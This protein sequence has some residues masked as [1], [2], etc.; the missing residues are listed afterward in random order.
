MTYFNTGDWVENCTSLVETEDGE[1]D[2]ECF[3]PWTSMYSVIR[4]PSDGPLQQ[5]PQR[6][7]LA[8]AFS[9]TVNLETEFF[10]EPVLPT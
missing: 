2:I 3:Y 4:R 7:T 8:P 6:P 10:E 1:F 9:R 5:L